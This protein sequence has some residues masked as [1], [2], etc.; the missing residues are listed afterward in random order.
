MQGWQLSA[1]SR[2]LSATQ[3]R[4]SY[5]AKF[6]QQQ[7]TSRTISQHLAQSQ[8]SMTLHPLSMSQVSHS[9]HSLQQSPTLLTSSGSRINPEMSEKQ[10]AKGASIATPIQVRIIL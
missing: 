7:H 3:P 5:R 8:H 1:H 2:K 10:T 9:P 4:H 6:T